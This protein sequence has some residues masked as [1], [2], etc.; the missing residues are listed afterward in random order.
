M[1]GDF[2]ISDPRTVYVG[3]RGTGNKIG[4]DV[5]NGGILRIN[6]ATAVDCTLRAGLG[7]STTIV[8][9]EG[10]MTMAS[11]AAAHLCQTF[12]LHGQWLRQGAGHG[13]H[14]TV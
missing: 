3:G 10:S 4:L 13:Q 8:V 9:G 7:R 2:S 1:L 5:D 6:Q 14:G 11:G 12:V